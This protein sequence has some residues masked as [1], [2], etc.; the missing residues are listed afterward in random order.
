[1]KGC[2]GLGLFF[3]SNDQIVI[4]A[5][6]NSDWKTC[7]DSRRSITGY[8]VFLR[9]SLILWKSKKQSIMSKSSSEA[10]YRVLASLICELQWLQCLLKL[11]NYWVRL[12]KEEKSFQKP[13]QTQVI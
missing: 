5:F 3:S 1:L 9:N 11:D 8:C 10:E 12:N 4:K 2:P 7:I 6:S 13:F